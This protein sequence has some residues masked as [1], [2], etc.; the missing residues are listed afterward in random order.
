MNI[1]PKQ[2]SE[3]IQLSVKKALKEMLPVLLE[4]EM[5]K[6]KHELLTESKPQQRD[7]STYA[8]TQRG[9][10]RTQS[11]SQVRINKQKSSRFSSDP[12][13]ND[14]LKN[15]APLESTSL[16]NKFMD[17]QGETSN[18]NLPTTEGGMPIQNVPSSVL[19]AMNKD[20]SGMFKN[21][22]QPKQNISQRPNVNN[23]TVSSIMPNFESSDG[24]LSYLDVF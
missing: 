23:H 7:R 10:I 8:L 18:V 17:L 5:K 12:V 24:D 20:Y 4:R 16:R 9:D 1:N 3:L 22:K 11:T 2:L 19:E 15:T 21:E 14:V 6:I 13:L